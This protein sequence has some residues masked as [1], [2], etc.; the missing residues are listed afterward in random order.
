M[1]PLQILANGVLFTEPWSGTTLLD[2]PEAAKWMQT[3]RQ[4]LILNG[5]DGAIKTYQTISYEYILYYKQY[6]Q[7]NNFSSIRETNKCPF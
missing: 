1:A 5:P 3:N 4:Y 7:Q 6:T 2:V